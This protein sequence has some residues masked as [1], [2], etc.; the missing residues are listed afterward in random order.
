MAVGAFLLMKGCGW[1]DSLGRRP[2]YR[3]AA[4]LDAARVDVKGGVG[5]T[6]SQKKKGGGVGRTSEAGDA[7]W[8]LATYPFPEPLPIGLSAPSARDAPV[9]PILPFLHTLPFPA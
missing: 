6:A 4:A 7:Y 8:P 9:S 3:G 2:T 1:C 5:A